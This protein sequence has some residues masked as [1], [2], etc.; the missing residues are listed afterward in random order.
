[1]TPLAVLCWFAW[2]GVVPV[3]DT[4]IAWTRTLPAL[5]VFTLCALGEYVVD[6]LPRTPSR[7]KLP[8][9]LGRL[10]MGIFVGCLIASLLGQPIAGGVIFGGAGALIGTYGGYSVRM[11]GARLFGRDLPMALL[12]SAAVV[13]LCIL[14]LHQIHEDLLVLAKHA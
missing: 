6:T 10:A 11:R 5:I 14:A 1:M 2:L 7:K 8:L 13:A 9:M 12:E 4:P 3:A